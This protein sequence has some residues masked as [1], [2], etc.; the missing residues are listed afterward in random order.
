MH[1]EQVDEV[2]NREWE[3]CVGFLVQ[4]SALG[5]SGRDERAGFKVFPS[6]TRACE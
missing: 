4:A 6:Q 5:R 2:F 3:L 1:K